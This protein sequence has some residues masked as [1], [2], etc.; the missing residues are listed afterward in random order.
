MSNRSTA[1]SRRLRLLMLLAGRKGL[2][3]RETVGDQLGWPIE[4]A[5]DELADAVIDGAI[6]YNNRAQAYRLAASPI[7]R[8]AARRLVLRKQERYMLGQWSG[9]GHTYHVGMAMLKPLPEADGPGRH[10]LW[11]Q[12]DVPSPVAR[13]YRLALKVHDAFV[14]GALIDPAQE[15]AEAQPLAA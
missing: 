3:D 9:D 13:D 15:Q 2:I 10:L 4:R 14:A 8:E 5:E 12:I 11:V 6:E 1:A 7:C